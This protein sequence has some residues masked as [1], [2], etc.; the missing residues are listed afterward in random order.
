MTRAV[1]IAAVALCWAHG[2]HAQEP[3]LR[4]FC[5]RAGAECASHLM[6][7][8]SVARTLVTERERVTDGGPTPDFVYYEPVAGSHLSWDVGVLRPFDNGSAVGV[9]GMVGFGSVGTRVAARAHYRVPLSSKVGLGT[10]VGYLRATVGGRDERTGTGVIADATL[11]LEHQIALL[12]RAET[13]TSE[14]LGRT[15]AAYFGATLRGRNALYGTGVVGAVTLVYVGIF[16]L[17]VGD[18]Y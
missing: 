5:L 10:A 13:L 2:V 16:A 4:A 18:N 9:S 7:D 3:E 15:Q 12:L 1:V 11:E 14:R 8:L 17:L 6:F